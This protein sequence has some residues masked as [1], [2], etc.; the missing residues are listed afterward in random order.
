MGLLGHM[1]SVHLTSEETA[2]L[3]SKVTV[4]FCIPTTNVWGF[5][6]FHIFINTQYCCL[7]I[8]V[9]F[10]VMSIILLCISLMPNYV[11]IFSCAG[12]CVFLL[13]CE[14][15]LYILDTSPSSNNVFYKYI[16]PLCGLSFHFLNCVCQRVKFFI[17]VKCSLSIKDYFF[18]VFLGSQQ[19]WEEGTKIYPLTYKCIVFPIISIPQQGGT[20]VVIENIY[21]CNHSKS[22]VYIRAHSCHCIFCQFRQMYSD[23][24]LPL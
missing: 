9:R 5:Q 17:L 12:K 10:A 18:K 1:V 13:S 15:S 6:M 20:F 16:L 8:L 7:D 19:N 24:C 2:R 4:Q 11:N 3:F 21:W 23:M 22:I 14:S